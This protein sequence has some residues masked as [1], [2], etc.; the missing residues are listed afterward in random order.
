MILLRDGVD[1]SVKEYPKVDIDLSKYSED[2]L[3][4]ISFEI[5]DIKRKIKEK[6]DATKV[7]YLR[8]KYLSKWAYVLDNSRPDYFFHYVYIK[9]VISPEVFNVIEVRNYD[10]HMSRLNNSSFMLSMSEIC[11]FYLK[12]PEEKLKVLSDEKVSEVKAMI[13]AMVGVFLDR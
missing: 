9:E 2:E 6:N 10:Q 1:Y 11:T 5:E 7:D 8:K 3:D 12:H 13:N 4:S